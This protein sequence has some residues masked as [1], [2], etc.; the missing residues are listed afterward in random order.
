M[1]KNRPPANVFDLS[2]PMGPQLR[3]LIAADGRSKTDIAL[4]AGMKPQGLNNIINGHRVANFKTLTKIL[5]AIGGGIGCPACEA[6]G[7]CPHCHGKGEFS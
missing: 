1:A 3:D 5:K 6:T 4:A 7:R 2:R